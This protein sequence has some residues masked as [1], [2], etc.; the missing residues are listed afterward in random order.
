MA[1]GFRTSVISLIQALSLAF[2]ID[3]VG[4]KARLGP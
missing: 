2:S 3:S 1:Q 4:I